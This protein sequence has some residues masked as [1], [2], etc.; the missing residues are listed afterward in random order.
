MAETKCGYSDGPKVKG[1]ILLAAYG[2]TLLV[3]IGFD[4]N[5][6]PIAN[7]HAIP[8]PGIRSVQA[9]VDTGASESCIDSMLAAQLSLPQVNKRRVSGVHGQK[10]VSV[11]LAQIR[12]PS[13]NVTINGMF[14]G[15]DLKAGGQ[16]HSALIGRSF[17][18][19]FHM[20]YEGNTGTVIIRSV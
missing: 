17:L 11:F 14:C 1:S 20:V 6:D 5:H 8:T 4:P 18:N 12:V 16:I 2:P 3:D 15:V 10:E 19:H 9:L 13:L 7:P